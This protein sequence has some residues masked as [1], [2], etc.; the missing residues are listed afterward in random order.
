MPVKVVS[1]D[2]PSYPSFELGLENTKINGL[3]LVS[4][5]VSKMPILTAK[6]LS[7][8]SLSSRMKLRGRSRCS[9][10]LYRQL[11]LCP[12][13]PRSFPA[14]KFTLSRYCSVVVLI[15]YTRAASDHFAHSHTVAAHRRSNAIEA[16]L[17]R[18]DRSTNEASAPAC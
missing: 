9:D 18:I 17:V 1:S 2:Y 4:G 11:G 8:V 5:C 12:P 14:A 15:F 10:A 13:Y 7:L 3:Q 6:W 16:F